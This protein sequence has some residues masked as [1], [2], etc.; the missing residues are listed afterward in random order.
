M[1]DAN[2]LREIKPV[3]QEVLPPR[4]WNRVLMSKSWES[5]WTLCR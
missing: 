5:H 1:F 4:P 2:I 3:N